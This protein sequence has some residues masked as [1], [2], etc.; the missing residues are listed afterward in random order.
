[1]LTTD[2]GVNGNRERDLRNK[3]GL[4]M[5]YTPRLFYDGVTHP[6]WLLGFLL[7]GMPQLGNFASA[8]SSDVEIQAAVRG[9]HRFRRFRCEL[10]AGFRGACLDDDRPT[11][12]GSRAPASAQSA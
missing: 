6:R 7:N 9:E 8:D 2:V 11:L 10:A 5:H 4:P 3:F 1:V 12:D